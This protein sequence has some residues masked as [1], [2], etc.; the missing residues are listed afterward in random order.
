MISFEELGVEKDLINGIKE[1]GFNSPMPVQEQVIEYLLKDEHSDL[2]A[3]AQTGTGKTAAFG[4]PL[5]Q[6]TEIKINSIQHLILAPTRELCLQIADDLVNYS[7]FKK[8]LKVVAVFG[9]ASIES[10]IRALKKGAHIISATPGRLLDLINRKVID[11]KK[12]KSVV[13]D[14]ADEMLNMGFKDELEAI[15]K[16]T[17]TEKHTY[18]FS[19]T[20]PKEISKIAKHYMNDPYEITIG[21]INSSSDLIEHIC[22]TVHAK[23][24]YHALKRIVDNSP[25]IYGIVFCRTR[26]E[27]KNVAEQLIH[28]GYN[29][30][31]IH[32]DL[33][34]AQRDS[35]MNKFRIKNLNLLVATD[36]AARG[37]DVDNLTHIINYN[38]PDELELYTHRSGRTGRAGRRGVSIVI[39]NLKEK[40]KV[41]QIEKRINKK[42]THLQ[43][44]SGKEIYEK[45]LWRLI[46][47]IEKVEVDTTQIEPYVQSILKKLEWLDRD[48]L[49]KK[50]VSIEFNRFLE[51][52]SKV[53][54]LNIPAD[55]KSKSTRDNYNADFTRFFI[56]I[57]KVDNLN[58]VALIGM[59]NDFTNKRNIEIG[60]IEI[61]KNFSFFEIDSKFTDKILNAFKNKS[62]KKR[63]IAVEI[64]ENKRGGRK[65]IKKKKNDNSK[66]SNSKTF[67][68]KNWKKKK[69]R[70]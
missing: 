63:K 25:D 55:S 23:D 59:I 60:D 67:K 19:A 58:P 69:M 30:E 24:R 21:S 8:G 3:L 66:L 31:A 36:V 68:S 16:E 12:I 70:N 45:Q 39:T 5:L 7:K 38:L 40:N 2:L 61:L 33:S 10:Q 11:L 47:K 64:A 32:G 6:N 42:F 65:P 54:D 4:L 48:E 1:L 53:P 29:A 13:L 62:Y 28:D 9:G 56:N 27:T 41:K 50:F 18:L 34:Q 22:Y 20:M 37:I 26:A 51:Y 46:D 35:V 14:E 44:P 43:V 49:I 57:G 17:P 52:Y 15:L